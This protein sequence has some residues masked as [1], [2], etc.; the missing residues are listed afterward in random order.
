[1]ILSEYLVQ[2]H[3]SSKSK[4]EIIIDNIKSKFSNYKNINN[5]AIINVINIKEFA[6]NVDGVGTVTLKYFNIQ[7]IFSELGVS[8]KIFFPLLEE[9]N[10]QT[11]TILISTPY[12]KFRIKES[13]FENL[14]HLVTFINT[15]LSTKQIELDDY[16][17][18]F[19]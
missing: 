10:D 3:N 13:S 8:K 6:V 2:Y 19:G 5:K 17:T 16:P 9:M 11:G 15:E 18:L 4:E 12:K 14:E 7:R 1:M